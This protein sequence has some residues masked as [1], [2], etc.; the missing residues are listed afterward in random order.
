M[1]I[2]LKL[3]QAF[4]D[5]K[6]MEKGTWSNNYCVIENIEIGLY[7]EPDG[8]TEYGGTYTLQVFDKDNVVVCRMI[9][10]EELMRQSNLHLIGGNRVKKLEICMK[11]G[12]VYSGVTKIE[13]REASELDAEMIYD[14]LNHWKY[15]EI[16][17]DG[18]TSI[19][20]VDC[21]SSINMQ[22]E[23]MK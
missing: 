23:V 17:H 16:L 22:N 9:T 2:N 19:I 12:G 11:N 1:T 18:G 5:W 14:L 4:P 10:E 8:D 3:S 21:I 6:D 7:R 13:E 15:W 20:I